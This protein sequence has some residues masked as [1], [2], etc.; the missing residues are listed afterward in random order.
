M[1]TP[2][3]LAIEID[4]HIDELTN[5]DLAAILATWKEEAWQEGFKCGYDNCCRAALEKIAGYILD[6]AT[7]AISERDLIHKIG[8][9]A[10]RAI[11]RA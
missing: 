4:L 11:I 1:K 8:T 6:W 10:D 7:D 3:E 5:A 2:E 9:E